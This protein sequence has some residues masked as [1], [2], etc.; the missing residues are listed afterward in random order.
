MSPSLKAELHQPPLLQAE[1]EQQA[2]LRFS[3]F[4]T[5]VAHPQQVGAETEHAHDTSP[6]FQKA[7]WTY[8][9]SPCQC[10]GH[11]H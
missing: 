1:N 8:M 7:P 5:S 3:A 6:Q 2:D 10:N 11:Y 4:D 9:P